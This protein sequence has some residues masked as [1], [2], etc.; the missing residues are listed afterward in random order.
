M[1][2]IG[3]VPPCHPSRAALAVL[4]IRPGRGVR[5][6][7][8][9]RALEE[10]PADAG[11]QAIAEYSGEVARSLRRDEGA[12]TPVRI[13]V[14]ASAL[15]DAG[16][17]LWSRAGLRTAFV[18]V[19]GSK[20]QDARGRHPAPIWRGQ[21]IEDLRLSLEQQTFEVARAL[22]LAERF[23]SQLAAIR[24]KPPRIDDDDF[25]AVSGHAGENLVIATGVALHE[26]LSV[27]PQGPHGFSVFTVP[28]P[29][30]SSVWGAKLWDRP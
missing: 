5:N 6:A 28:Q 11:L 24:E 26:G 8:A 14:E 13:V 20:P 18:H 19:T 12:P 29:G 17:G 7:A 22:S 9:L 25:D 10:F 1:Y 30:P 3:V 16:R 27:R 21:I 4:H 23:T 2:V 15:G